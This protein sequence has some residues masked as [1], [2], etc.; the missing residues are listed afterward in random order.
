MR[1]SDSGKKINERKRHLL[2]DT[3][4]LILGVK[5]QLADIMDCDGVIVSLEAMRDRFPR[6]SHVWL[7]GGHK[8]K[9]KGAE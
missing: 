7:G 9:G 1:C 8:G 4:G 6:L 3:Q 5:V 2:V